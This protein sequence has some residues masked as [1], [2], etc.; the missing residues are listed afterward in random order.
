M[1][2]RLQERE[3]GTVSLLFTSHELVRIVRGGDWIIG[4]KNYISTNVLI[5]EQISAATISPFFFCFNSPDLINGNY[6]QACSIQNI[7]I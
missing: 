5:S 3:R 7:Y 1:D 6:L 2:S 4:G